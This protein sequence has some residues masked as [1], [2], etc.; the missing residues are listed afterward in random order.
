M[1]QNIYVFDYIAQF[2]ISDNFLKMILSHLEGPSLRITD[3]NST[4]FD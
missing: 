4:N 1:H 2:I 3:L